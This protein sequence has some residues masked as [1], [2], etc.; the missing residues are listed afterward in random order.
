MIP[1]QEGPGTSNKKQTLVLLRRPLTCQKSLQISQ[2]PHD[3]DKARESQPITIY[4]RK[5]SQAKIFT[6]LFLFGSPLP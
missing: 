6:E 4:H 3:L 2:Y 5:T 1:P